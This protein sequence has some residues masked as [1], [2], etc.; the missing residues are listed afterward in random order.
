M[1]HLNP[2]QFVLITGGNQMVI[3]QGKLN[4]DTSGFETVKKVDLQMFST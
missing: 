3:G 2:S 4:L 1:A